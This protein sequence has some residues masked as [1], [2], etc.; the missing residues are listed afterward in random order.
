VIALRLSVRGHVQGVWY[1]D[2]TVQA[3]RNLGVSGWVR[4][5]PD[6]TVEAHAQG[7]ETAVHALLARMHEGPPAARVETI[8]SVECE[9]EDLEGFQRR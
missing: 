7:D 5:C 1:R 8:D 3:A 2:W 9:R 4:N 6:G